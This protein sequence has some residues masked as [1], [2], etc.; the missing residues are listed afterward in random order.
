[1]SIGD[2]FGLSLFEALAC[3]LPAIVYDTPPFD[4]LLPKDVL[5]KVPKKSIKKINSALLDYL[6][7]DEREKYGTRAYNFVR[8][9]FGLD[10]MASNYFRLL[11]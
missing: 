11:E 10:K 7:C 5:K 2:A 4:K 1:M 3:G 8:N 6:D 9:N